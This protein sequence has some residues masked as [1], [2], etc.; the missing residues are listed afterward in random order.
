M[1]LQPSR[2]QILATLGTALLPVSAFANGTLP[3][4]DPSSEGP[5]YK[6]GAPEKDDLIEPGL[7][8]TPLV[9][10]GRVLNVHGDPLSHA[11]LDVWEAKMDGQYDSSGY[12]LRGKL[13]TRADGTYRLRT[14]VP[15]AYK[16]GDGY[17]TAHIH[18]KVSAPDHR[19]ITTELYVKGEPRN[20]DDFL[21]RPSLQ[22]VLASAG[23]GKQASF[24]FVLGHAG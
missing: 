9:L 24:D 11:L 10:T 15:K 12:T 23:E 21:A 18:L 8:G 22:L 5:A 13:Y 3:V 16:A 1:L 20:Y 19:L 2:R 4:T 14:L 6:P 17:R 7:G